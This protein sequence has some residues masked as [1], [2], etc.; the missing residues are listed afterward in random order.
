M[1]NILRDQKG[2]EKIYSIIGFVILILA[3]FL[4]YSFGVPYFKN[5]SLNGY[6]QE[7]VNYDYLNQR[8]SQT[9]AKSIYNK[10]IAFAKKKSLPIVDSHIKVDYDTQEYRVSIRYDYPVN[11]I[12][13]K[14]DW[15][16][17]V[18]R[19]SESNY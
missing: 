3:L 11:L 8:P 1:K 18:N 13:Y 4:I 9:E 15:H 19:K 17:E 6:A 16:F 14:F 12:V 7:L 10:L 2:S 5:M